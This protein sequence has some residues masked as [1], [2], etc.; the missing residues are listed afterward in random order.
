MQLTT[1]RA[2]RNWVQ[3]ATS[4]VTDDRRNHGRHPFF[5]SITI[6]NGKTDGTKLA[7]FSREV[8]PGG[9]GLLHN[10]PLA[11]QHVTLTVPTIAGHEAILKTDIKWCKPCGADWFLSGGRLVRVSAL[12][13][14]RVRMAVLCSELIRR[15]TQRLPFYRPVA[16]ELG[17][18]QAITMSAISRD[19]SC[20]G[21]ELLHNMPLES[22]NVFLT[23]DQGTRIGAEILWCKPNGFGWYISGVRFI[24]PLFEEMPSMLL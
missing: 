19:I 7:A 18:S 21:I 14:A 17:G 22:R 24:R 15:F 1:D 5:R 9:I 2:I 12:D 6:E 8:S 20:C 3:E 10:A 23:I 4:D 16:I 11:S 13:E